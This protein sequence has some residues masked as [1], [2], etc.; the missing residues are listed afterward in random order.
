M[1]LRHARE[2]VDGQPIENTFI[3][4]D[5][6][7]GDQL[8]ACTI[9][10]D[11]NPSLYPN[12]PFQ[13]CMQIDGDPIPDRLLGASFARARELC[14]ASGK[15]CRLYTRCDP[16]NDELM[17]NLS[18]L[19]FKDN[20]GLVKMRLRLPAMHDHRLPAGC[21]IVKDD[22]KDPIEQKYFLERYNQI[23]NTDHD[24]AWLKSYIDRDGFMRILAVSATGMAGEILIWREQECGVIGYIQTSKRWRHLGVGTSL[25]A[26]A[27]EEFSRR[28][29]YA[30]EVNV[31]ARIPYV[32]TM[33]EKL[34]FNQSELLMRYP[35]IDINPV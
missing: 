14:M 5:E 6:R 22:L 16:D 25:V 27:C 29:L 8:G 11:D 30:A 13:V 17:E 35:G 1:M 24:F 4:I 15:F 18:A 7:S 9:F 10:C 19:G 26:M 3:A 23:Y 33:M 34:G 12:R 21:T 28:H 2:P 32:L 20:D 31:R